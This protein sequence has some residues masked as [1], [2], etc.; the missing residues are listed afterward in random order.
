MQTS[1]HLERKD[2]YVKTAGG[3]DNEKLTSHP[4]SGAGEIVF[5]DHHHSPLTC[6]PWAKKKLAAAS[7]TDDKKLPEVPSNLDYLAKPDLVGTEATVFKVYCLGNDART[8]LQNNQHFPWHHVRT[9]V[10][11][12]SDTVD[13]S[14]RQMATYVGDVHQS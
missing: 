6:H 13:G 14:E 12:K 11:I 7:E 8:N 1:Q 5:F 2:W 4:L 10:E 3:R 9:I